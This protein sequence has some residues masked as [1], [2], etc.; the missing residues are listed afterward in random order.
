MVMASQEANVS[1]MKMHQN[2]GMSGRRLRKV[3]PSEPRLDPQFSRNNSLERFGQP[4]DSIVSLPALGQFTPAPPS[5]ANES[6]DG[7]NMFITG[8]DIVTKRGDRTA[9][10]SQAVSR[11]VS[12]PY[13]SEAP[14]F[15]PNS[16]HR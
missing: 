12:P 8:K 5:R 16:P 9:V 11:A 15:E 3:R 13:L 10:G 6:I 1:N 4:K 7:Q 14:A 2:I